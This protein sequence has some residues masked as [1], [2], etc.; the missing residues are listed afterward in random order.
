[1]KLPIDAVSGRR[2]RTIRETNKK[3]WYFTS[4]GGRIQLPPQIPKDM[5]IQ[6]GDLYVHR[7]TLVKA[8]GWRCTAVEPT[9]A[10]QSLPAGTSEIGEDGVTR[11]FVITENGLPGW[12]TRETLQRKYKDLQKRR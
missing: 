8:Q 10:W 12:V 9:V 4:A 11:T 6:V 7:I 3:F 5:G 1:M 2:G